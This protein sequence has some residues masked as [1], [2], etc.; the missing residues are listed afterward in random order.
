MKKIF[1]AVFFVAIGMQIDVYELW[2][3]AGL[4]GGIA[5][6]TLVAR[7]LA[8]TSALALSGTPLKDALRTGLTGTPIGEFSFII[9][10]LGVTMAVVPPRFYPMAVGVSLV[11][12][13]IAPMLTRHS[14]KIADAILRRQPRWLADWGGAYLG[15]LDGLQQRRSRNLLW[16]LSRKRLIQ[17]GVGTLFVTG[18]VVFS[19]QFFSMA[20]A[21]IGRD[22]L[23]PHD[24]ELCFGATLVLL[25]LAPLVAIWRNVS[26][27]AMLYAEVST[28]GHPHAQRLRT[29]V[30]TVLKIIAGGGMFVWLAA[31]QPAE[32]QGQWLLLF[33]AVVAGV[34]LLVLRRKLIYWHSE[35]EVELISV[36]ETGDNKMTATTAPWLQPHGEWNLHMID[37]TLPDLADCQ[38]KKISE[39]GLR[40]RFGC[41]V[42]GI[43]R[44]GFMIPLPP[45]EA[46]LFPRDKVLLLGTSEQV[47]AGKALL[48]VVSGASGSDSLFGEVRMEAMLVPR[49]SPAAGRTLG[50][51]SPAQIHGVQIAGVNR[52][53]LR[54]LNPT[55]AESMRSGDEV[56]VLGAPMQIAKFKIWL[57]E[58]VEEEPAAL[59]AD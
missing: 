1:S 56:L 38:G 14:E 18:V 5:A 48:G 42:V 34:A 17:V 33:S 12:T 30:E 40:S 32:G 47:T 51:L 15:W 11:T 39:L 23:F 44:Q 8:V 4:I 13:L 25:I 29:L 10:Q 28:K 52:N 21:W 59:K 27:M 6:F 45:P 58:R 7:P 9:A 24:L 53:G 31:I 26:A 43:E 37:C 50:E 55:A 36:I 19:G 46:V 3:A 22:R 16:Q 57:R 49:W 35:M 54:V 2:G 20:E 41:S